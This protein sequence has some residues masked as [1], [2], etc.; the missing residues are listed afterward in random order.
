LRLST[1]CL[2][3]RP[4]ASLPVELVERKG[5]GHPDTLCDTIAERASAAYARY[6]LQAFGRLAHH[7]FDKV[8]LLGGEAAIDFGHG[9]LVRPYTVIFSGKAA[10]TV[11]DTEIPV[12]T[13]L[14]DTAREVLT[15]TLRNFD[16]DRH[17]RV[18][19]RLSDY[20]GPGQARSRYRPAEP[21]DLPPVDGGHRVANDCCI[22]TAFAPM[23][24]LEGLVLEVEHHIT[25]AG[26]AAE[27]P[28]TGSD[29]K[30]LGIREEDRSM[31]RVSLPFIADLVPS[32]QTY[33]SRVDEVEAHL[34]DHATAVTGRPVE[35]VVNPERDNRS[36]LTA[37]GTVCDTGDIGVVG[38][39]NRANGLITPMRPMSIE[40]AAGKNPLD[41]SG[42]I[43]T[44]VCQRVAASV[45]DITGADTEVY[46]ATT[47]ERPL[48]DP[49]R[50][51][52]MVASEANTLVRH[53]HAIRHVV[54][55][56]LS[57]TGSLTSEF[58][59][60]VVLW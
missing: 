18:E 52:V 26:F 57:V 6:C 58:L 54:E 33:L 20:Q 55:E 38:R 1:D 42:K 34:R 43:Y 59:D 39:G 9:E 46:I 51:L 40:A 7:W 15:R 10:F 35:V 25:S 13:I 22:C 29:V 41:H 32:R 60:G 24:V 37:T 21:A 19:I 16:P 44:A 11:G 31:L 27:N 4:V 49:E 45:A 56:A 30:V 12:A 48:T 53:K 3:V 23:T 2:A 17:V 28:D 47:K 36:Y 14:A 5:R 8:M 50:V